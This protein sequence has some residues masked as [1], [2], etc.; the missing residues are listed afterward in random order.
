MDGRS[1]KYLRPQ[2]S[3]EK[4]TQQRRARGLR[5]ANSVGV[6]YSIGGG[7]GDAVGDSDGVGDGDGG[8]EMSVESNNGLSG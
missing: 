2:R 3:R 5:A 1:T 7:V 8:G 4:N 6:G